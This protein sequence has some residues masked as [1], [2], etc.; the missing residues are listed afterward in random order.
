MV[1]PARRCRI[2]AGFVATRMHVAGAR[3]MSV[4][5]RLPGPT[6]LP[7]QVV[8]ALGRDDDPASRSGVPSSL[9]RDAAAGA[10]SPPHRRR[11][12][13]L[14]GHRLGWLGSRHRQSPLAGRSRAGRRSMEISASGSRG[15]RRRL[16]LDVRRLDVAVGGARFCPSSCGRRS[17]THPDV[18]AVFLVHN[19]TSTGVTN[20]LRELAAIV[21]DHGALVIVDAVSA[22]GALPLEVDAWGIDFVFSG[23]QKA[24]M[25]PPGLLIVAAGAARLGGARAVDVP[26]VLLGHERGEEDGGSGHDAD[27]AAAVDDLRVPGGAGHDRRRRHRTGLGAP[28]P[29]GCD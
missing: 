24:W 20:P 26:A 13:D 1:H 25:C 9:P 11:C 12:P 15:W 17:T 19:E 7:P 8:A 23:S 6:P 2:A 14:G 21:R 22:A 18:K 29:P 4:N 28:S 5:F 16:G 3:F 10:G 27:D